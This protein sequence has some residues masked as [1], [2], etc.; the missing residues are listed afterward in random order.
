MKLSYRVVDVEGG[1][2][3]RDVGTSKEMGYETTTQLCC[4]LMSMI[5]VTPAGTLQHGR[6]KKLSGKNVD[7][8]RGWTVGCSGGGRWDKQRDRI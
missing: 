3:E 4:G 7:T 6:C 2:G 1:I 5:R 8:H